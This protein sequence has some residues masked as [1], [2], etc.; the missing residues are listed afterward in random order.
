[1]AKSG[2]QSVHRAVDILEQLASEP[3][4]GLRLSELSRRLNLTPQTVQSL[5]RTLENRRLVAQTRRSGPYVLGY[6]VWELGNRWSSGRDPL[7]VATNEMK[8]LRDILHEQI[9]LAELYRDQ[10]VSILEIRGDHVLSVSSLPYTPD[11]THTMATAKV[12]LAYAPQERR[13]ATISGMTFVRRGPKAVRSAQELKE[14]L[15]DIRNRGYAVCMDESHMGITAV[16]VPIMDETDNINAALGTFLP[17]AR[18][19]A[20]NRNRILQELRRSAEQLKQSWV[21]LRR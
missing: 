3:Q 13:D 11:R 15:P 6:R 4:D 5:L 18:F 2:V 12:L 9:V 7:G 14:Q 8:R 10:V 20:K 17:T 16:A 1:M 21:P 19:D